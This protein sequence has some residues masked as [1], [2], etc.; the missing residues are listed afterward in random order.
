MDSNFAKAVSQCLA[1][2][3]R[4]RVATCG[5]VARALG[6]VRA[7][8]AVAT[9]LVDHPDTPEGHRV[10]RADGRPVLAQAR[11]RLEREGLHL[12]RGRVD[13]SRIVASLPSVKFLGLLRAEQRRLA[14][15][16][17]ERDTPGPIE[18]IG[19]VD[20]GYQGDEMY[21][22]AVSIALGNLDTIE[23]ALVRRRVDFPY[24]PTYLAYREFPG[25]ESAVRRLSRRPDVL[26]IDG[27]GRLHPALFG[28]ACYAGIRLDLPTIGVAKHPLAGRVQP[29]SEKHAAA[30]SV[31]IDGVTRG[32]AW[33]P[34]NR[35][36]A[37]YVSVGHRIS[38]PRALDLVRKTTQHRY[39]EALRIADRVS[40]EIK[41]NEKREKGA[42]R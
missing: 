24:I 3:P 18:I 11:R 14:S 41:G 33:T 21:A 19:G 7:A 1:E 20:V 2:I 13:D 26:M 5:A 36:R 23:I 40:R 8:R 37:I 15:R 42:A 39:P 25:I 4:R 29:T 16:V 34:P 28:I 10:V 22:V 6:D 32:Y 31:R 35:S 27:H 17:I 38:L 9:W 12:A 30:H